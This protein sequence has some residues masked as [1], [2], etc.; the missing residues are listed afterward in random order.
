MKYYVLT[1]EYD[2]VQPILDD[3]TGPTETGCDVVEVSAPNKRAARKLAWPQIKQMGFY[4]NHYD[5]DRHPY[6]YLT[7]EPY[8]L[9]TKP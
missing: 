1:P 9:E 5:H 7:V 2:T 6:A 8:E 3:G 4:R